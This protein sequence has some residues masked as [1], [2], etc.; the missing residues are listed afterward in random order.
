MIDY[1]KGTLVYFKEEAVIVD[2]GGI[3]YRIFCPN[4]YAFGVELEETIQVFTHHHVREDAILLFGFPTRDEQ[5]LFRRLLEVTGIGPKGALAIL[6]GCTPEQLV[7]AIQHEDLGMLT[8]FPGIGKKTAQRM[9]LDLK[10]KLPA[11]PAAI[12]AGESPAARKPLH[13][14]GHTTAMEEAK[15]ALLSLGYTANECDRV[16]NAILADVQ[17]ATVDQIIKKALKEFMK[18]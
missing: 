8:K 9:I 7:T 17:E 14:K 6:A 2:V 13:P 12:G 3:G 11:W 5:E 18:G 16:L 1:I 10:D 4:P 15:E